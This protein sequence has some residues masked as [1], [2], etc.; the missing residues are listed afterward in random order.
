MIEDRKRKFTVLVDMQT[1]QWLRNKKKKLLLLFS[2]QTRINS[3]HGVVYIL[4]IL[5]QVNLK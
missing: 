2:E 5:N 3:T 4:S 1:H